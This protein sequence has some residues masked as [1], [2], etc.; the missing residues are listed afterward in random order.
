MK[1]SA[2][3]DS[4]V[5]GL[6]GEPS[7]RYRLVQ[8]GDLPHLCGVGYILQVIGALEEGAAYRCD[9]R[10]CRSRNDSPNEGSASLCWIL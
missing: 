7:I 2:A 6:V 1:G 9:R 10:R 3:A 5:V 4:V 8:I